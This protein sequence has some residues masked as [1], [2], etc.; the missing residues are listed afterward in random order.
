MFS[1]GVSERSDRAAIG[2]LPVARVIGPLTRLLPGAGRFVLYLVLRSVQISHM[3]P[4]G[5]ALHFCGIGTRRQRIAAS[6]SSLTPERNVRA[7][8]HDN[9][10]IF[11]GNRANLC[12]RRRGGLRSRRAGRVAR[13]RSVRHIAGV[14]LGL[15]GIGVAASRS[16]RRRPRNGVGV[17]P[18]TVLGANNFNVDARLFPGQRSQAAEKNH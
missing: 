13:N 7:I 18:L 10:H 1:P 11:L 3:Y 4:N 12:R 2:F 17:L 14:V 15:I 8:R 9:M 16:L 5:V 6:P